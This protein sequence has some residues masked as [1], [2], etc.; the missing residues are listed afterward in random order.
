MITVAQSIPARF[1]VRLVIGQ[2]WLGWMID[3]RLVSLRGHPPLKQQIGPL[4]YWS[5]WDY[6]HIQWVGLITYWDQQEDWAS[7]ETQKLCV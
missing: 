6:T 2:S 1:D 7:I 3:Y 4:Q 5:T